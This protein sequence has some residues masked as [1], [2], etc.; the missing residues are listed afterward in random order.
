MGEPESSGTGWVWQEGQVNTQHEHMELTFVTN[1]H[2]FPRESMPLALVARGPEKSFTVQFLVTPTLEHPETAEAL[3]QARKTLDFY[4]TE[5]LG[6][7]G[8]PRRPQGTRR[9]EEY[10]PWRY[11]IYHATSTAAN[12]Y[13]QIHWAY[14]PK[15]TEA[16]ARQG[17]F[18]IP[19]SDQGKE[20]Q[21]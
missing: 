3:A 9:K 16:G 20:K 15:G 7:A 17:A 13:A 6:P 2:A 1:P 21:S 10:N 11:A 5:H 12:L 8:F 19:L 14:F 4:L 18:I